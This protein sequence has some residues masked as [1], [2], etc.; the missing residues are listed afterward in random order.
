MANIEKRGENSYRFTVYLPINAKGIYPKERMPYKVEGKFTP[1]QLEEHLEHEYLKF[2]TQV[3]SGNYIRPQEMTFAE[4]R[5]EW[6]VKYAS[7]LAGTTHGNHQR[8]L[9]L[10]ISPVLDHMEMKQINEFILMKLLDELER[11]DGKD[12]ELTYHSK[13]D[14]YG[15]LKSVFK[16]AVR[17][18]VLKDNPMDGVEKPKPTDTEEDYEEVQVY[19]EDEIAELMQLLQT[20]LPHWRVMFTLALAAGLRRG[21]LLGLE[22]NNVDFENN[23]IEIRTTI[24]LTKSGP[25]IKKTKTKSSRRTVTLPESMMAELRLF[26]D[27]Q[28]IEKT[29]AG[30]SWIEEE[31]NWVFRQR[32]GT[33]MY[34][35]SPTN[36][37]SKFLKK[38]E[39]KYIR[40]HDLRHTS[41]SILIAQ[42]AHAKIISERLGHS[43]IS[44]TMN[45]YGHAFKSADRAAANMLESI[46]KP[47]PK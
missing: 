17:W 28:E 36:R 39:F 21:E 31:Y 13:Q 47:R 10:H 26:Y 41:A 12:G 20:E 34:P 44:V 14:V 24:V 30:D 11:K 35:S 25:L 42:G 43:D 33:H 3:L 16:Y 40:L 2:K 9:E 45:T 7:K 27:Q 4:F 8:K 19:E 23:Q 22:W 1:K 18:K 46:F 15:T 32:D 5:T 37:W 38:H 6:D 29:D